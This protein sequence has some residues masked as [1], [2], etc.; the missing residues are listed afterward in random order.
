VAARPGL[1]LDAAE[2]QRAVALAELVW[3]NPFLP[4]RVELERAALGDAFVGAGEVWHKASPTADPRA[5]SPNWP[6]LAERAEG[7]VTA[8]HDRLAAGARASAEDSV[9]YRD[10]VF[11]V[12][13]QRYA[14][15]LFLLLPEEHKP[16]PA[17]HFAHWGEL[18]GALS[19]LLA[20]VADL[21]PGPGHGVDAAHLLACFFQVRRAF[22]YLH[23][24][25]LGASAG[26]ARLRAEAWH[27]VF[28]HD[29]RRYQRATWAQMADI[30]T[31]VTG[32]SGSGKELVARAIALSRHA[33][34]SPSE[35][36][37]AIDLEACF[38]PLNLGALPATLIESELFGHK[39]GSFTGAV[40]DRTG[41]LELCPPAGTV[42][43]DE[44][45]ELEPALQVKLLR[46]VEA[47]AFHRLGETRPRRFT[48][49]LVAATHRDLGTAMRDG[50]FREDLY[51][52]LCGDMVRTPS[53]AERLRDSPGELALL[54]A[55]LAHQLVGPDEG[56]AIA[57]ETVA[58]I[59]RS[60]PPEYPW[61]GNVRELGQCL[62]NVLLRREYHPGW[63]AAAVGE[64]GLAAEVAAGNL[65][66]QQLAR[67]YTTM[68]Y[69]RTGSY[70][71]AARRLGL[72][73][74]T[75][76]AY[77]DEDLLAELRGGVRRPAPGDEELAAEEEPPAT[78]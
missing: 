36:T 15:D 31:L 55:H 50:R 20:P 42:F 40:E 29:M 60:L 77:V 48:G 70:L 1:W 69:A 57:D 32:P 52:R 6:R 39:R 41:W 73:R 44:I 45:G 47:R 66:L 33:P 13:Y 16:A 21:L 3:C 22:H 14:E 72:D 18:N 24:F 7:L 49:K 19:R 51:Y 61:P 76:R 62:R 71:E 25:L 23:H 9:L 11:Y 38:F 27:S 8:L 35:R 34:F 37:F 26:A 10:L 12:L 59:Q 46:V 67:R 54:V 2:R 65:T 4:R 64:K 17:G 75:V 5:A 30:P 74:R 78:V 58:W 43:L 68:I 63:E 56:P 28:G 53:L